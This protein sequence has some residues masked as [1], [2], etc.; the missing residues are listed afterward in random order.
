MTEVL[1]PKSTLQEILWNFSRFQDKRRLTLKQNP[2]FYKHLNLP[3]LREAYSG[4]FQT[5]PIDSFQDAKICVLTDGP[6][7]VFLETDQN[8]RAFGNVW[9]PN[10]AMIFKGSRI[11]LSLPLLILI[12]PSRCLW[13]TPGRNC[14]PRISSRRV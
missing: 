11:T 14:R 6:G 10:G 7:R 1:S 5:E 13:K 3:P 12:R 2:H 8:S 4:D 9:E